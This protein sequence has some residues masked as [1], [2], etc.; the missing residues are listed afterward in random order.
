MKSGRDFAPDLFCYVLNNPLEVGEFC[1][2]M[3]GYLFV[4]FRG[5]YV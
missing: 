3:K 2:I 1:S 5:F 4:N